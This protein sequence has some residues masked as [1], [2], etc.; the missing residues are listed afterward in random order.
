MGF[1]NI[2]IAARTFSL[3][4]STRPYSYRVVGDSS[5]EFLDFPVNQSLVM[6]VRGEVESLACCHEASNSGSRT[7]L[8]SP[9]LCAVGRG[10]DKQLS[11][12]LIRRQ[13][14]KEWEREGSVHALM[15]S[16]Y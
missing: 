12:Y 8:A 3:I 11:N 9:R 4:I 6:E 10:L 13:A 15:Y 7:G 16:V 14:N 5:N 1:Q 2:I